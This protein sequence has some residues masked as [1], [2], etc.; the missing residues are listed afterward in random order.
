MPIRNRTGVALALAVFVALPATRADAQIRPTDRAPLELLDQSF[1]RCGAGRY[2][3]QTA[4]LAGT[5]GTMTQL[6]E[7]TVQLARAG[8]TFRVEGIAQRLFRDES[9]YAAPAQGVVEGGP[10]RADAGEWGI[11]VVVPL[12]GWL[13]A[14]RVGVRL[15][16]TDDR[17][18]LERDAT[19]AYATIS[20]LRDAGPLWLS[21][22]VGVGIH[23]T[24]N[25]EREQQDVLLFAVAA[26]GRRGA[27]SGYTTVVGHRFW[28]NEWTDRGNENLAELRVA[29]DLRV[30]E[31]WSL[32]AVALRGLA[33]HSP[34]AGVR[35]VVTRALGDA[36]TR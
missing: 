13:P 28:M 15:P 18:G 8:A 23:G 36:G 32:G 35:F 3:D 2:S 27:L 12:R 11:D 6:G 22:E 17:T 10:H 7:C 33:E 14:L 31:H 9:Q 25:L 30:S 21:G 4:T 29:A 26:G 24:R 5:R 1:V 16:T 34:A 20:G 19:D